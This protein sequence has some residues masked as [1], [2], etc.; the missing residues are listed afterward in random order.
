MKYKPRLWLLGIAAAGSMS[1]DYSVAANCECAPS[2]NL[3]RV[4]EGT[5]ALKIGESIDLTNSGVL[6][7]F[8]SDASSVYAQSTYNIRINGKHHAV[9]IG[10]RFDL[11]QYTSRLQ[12]RDECWLDFY[13][14]IV[15][16]GAPVTGEFRL[17]CP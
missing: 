2:A 16:K 5:F 10:E 7:T 1:S 14:V 8:L 15:A 9:Q 4:A 6:L 3:T 17:D 11:K 13:G 12:D